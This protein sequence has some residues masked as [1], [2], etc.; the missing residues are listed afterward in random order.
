MGGPEVTSSTA[1]SRLSP[2][3]G[4][5]GDHGHH[6]PRMRMSMKSKGEATATS[7]A[8][9]NEVIVGGR[10]SGSPEQ[11]ELPS[12]D[13]VVQLRL[14]VPRSGSRAAVGR[15]GATVDT[16]DVACWTKA[17][18]RK[19]VR[20]R[21]GDLVTVRG[22]LRRGSGVPRQGRPVATRLRPLRWTDVPLR[23]PRA[24]PYRSRWTIRR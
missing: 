9:V 18:Q 14:V 12:G 17:L 3:R 19:A 11:R 15:G 5:P 22:A 23:R 20:L 7:G 8:G 1:Q 21:P 24:R 16:I 2:Q 6:Q 10:I 13:T 4:R